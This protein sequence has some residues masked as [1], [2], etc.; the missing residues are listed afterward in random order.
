MAELRGWRGLHVP[1]ARAQASCRWRPAA[2]SCLTPRWRSRPRGRITKCVENRSPSFTSSSSHM[3]LGA[4]FALASGAASDL[5]G[6]MSPGPSARVLPPTPAPLP[7]SSL[8]FCEDSKSFDRPSRS[9]QVLKRGGGGKESK[10]MTETAGI[11]QHRHLKLEPSID[12]K[13]ARGMMMLQLW[14]TPLPCVG[15]GIFWSG[16]AAAL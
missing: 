14:F 2:A 6:P 10:R 12:V 13:P 9:L 5:L 8:A 16:T 3:S 4:A 15:G 1:C 11:L 7:A